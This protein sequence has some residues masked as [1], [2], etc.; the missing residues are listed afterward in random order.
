MYAGLTCRVRFIL[1]NPF[2]KKISEVLF[3]VLHDSLKHGEKAGFSKRL[4]THSVSLA[5][6]SKC[7]LINKYS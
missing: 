3:T 2:I 4:F 7:L 1:L 6:N 5:Q